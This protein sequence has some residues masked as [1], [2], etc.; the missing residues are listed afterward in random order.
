MSGASFG[1]LGRALPGVL[2]L[3]VCACSEGAQTQ[4]QPQSGGANSAGGSTSSSGAPSNTSGGSVAQGNGGASSG[5]SNSAAGGATQGAGGT[6]TAT[7]GGSSSGGATSGG[8]ANTGGT[9]T[10]SGGA[11]SGGRSSS[12]GSTSGGTT[13]TSGGTSTAS[14]GTTTSTSGGTTSTGA[15]GKV[16]SNP[17]TSCKFAWGAPSSGTNSSYLNFV[18]TWVGDETNG[19]LASMSATA[20]NTSCGDCNWVSQIASSNAMAVFYTYFIGFQACK[21][22]GYCDCN[23]SSGTTLC[24]NGAAWI[25]Q[26]R[27]IIINMYAQ[28]AKKVYAASP[29]KPVIWWLEG[30]FPQYHYT[31]QTSALSWEELGSLARDITC[32]I[33]SNQ[34]NAVVAMNHAP[35]IS[36]DESTAFWSAQPL[37]VLD[38]IWVQGAGDSAA[39][40]NSAAYNATT[41]NFAWLHTKT[42]KKIMAETSYAG[43]G[44]NDR[45]TTTTA[46]NIN[47]RISNGVI[48]VLVNNPPSNYQSTIGSFSLDSTCN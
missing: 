44:A 13:T 21:Q 14:G 35:W 2:T 45:W 32:A 24:T 41:A 30:D 11:V 28:Y 3:A 33:K 4:P 15:C 10:S 39:F 34:P 48:G 46:A 47:A 20:T 1:L 26:N 31:T 18:S 9:S 16:T 43:S 23:T 38:L 19:G 40:V 7:S 27:A 37:D 12:G 5:G 8:R 17:F 42:G 25:K 36:N 22:A 6:A 29:N